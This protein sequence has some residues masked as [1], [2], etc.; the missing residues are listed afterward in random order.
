MLQLPIRMRWQAMG[1]STATSIEELRLFQRALLL[2]VHRTRVQHG[3]DA[4]FTQART[5][6]STKLATYLPFPQFIVSTGA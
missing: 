1:T 5:D 2:S 6:P 4:D 3:N